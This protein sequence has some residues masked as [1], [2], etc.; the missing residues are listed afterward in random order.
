MD[1]ICLWA[2][3]TLVLKLIILWYRYRHAPVVFRGAS[4]K[5]ILVLVIIASLWNI[6]ED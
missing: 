4:M 6:I 1:W 5:I 2:G 3:D